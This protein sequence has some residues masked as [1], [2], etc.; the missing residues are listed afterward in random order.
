MKFK[1][2]LLVFIVLHFAKTSY[3]QNDYQI[4]AKVVDSAGYAPSG[5][6]LA[7]QPQD[8]SLIKGTFFYDGDLNIKVNV[9]KVLLKLTS[10]EFQDY[11]ILVDN[12][13]QA[14]LDLGELVVTIGT[15][16]L[17]EVVLSSSKPIYNRKQNGT[18]EVIVEN[19]LLS[20]SSNIVDVLS[21]TPEL[22]LTESGDLSV[23]G[24][25]EAAYYVNDR[26][27]TNEQLTL[28]APSNI[29]SIEIIRNPP[30]RYDAQGAAVI[31]IKTIRDMDNGYQ[32]ALGQ[33]ASYSE[34]GGAL[35]QTHFNFNLKKNK[36]Q[37]NA[38]YAL[39]LGKERERLLTS[40]DRAPENVFL[41]TDISNDDF[42]DFNNYSN[43]NLGLQYDINDDSY[44]S[45]DYSG[46]YHQL[47]GARESTNTIVDGM[48]TS[49]YDTSTEFDEEDGNNSISINYFKELDS[50]GSSLFGGGH[51]SK[52]DITTINPIE[53][54]E[55]MD[56]TEATRLIRNNQFL[57]IEILSG[58]LDFKN[59]LNASTSIESGIKYSILEN[60]FIADFRVSED[61]INFARD[62]DF[63]NTFNYQEKVAAGYVSIES[64]ISKKVDLALGVRAEHT[65][66]MLDDSR[67]DAVI[68][69][70]YLQF[71]PNASV[72]VSPKEGVNYS[73]SYISRL[74]RALYSWLNPVLVY[75][76]P[77]TG[78]QGNPQLV[79][80]LTHS[81]E[82]NAQYPNLNFLFGYKYVFDPFGQ[83]A[84]RGDSDN[85]YILTRIN[86]KSSEEFY[87]SLDK[88]YTIT[89]W[90]TSK[91]T[92][93]LSYTNLQ[94]DVFGFRRVTPRPQ[95]YY[96][97]NNSFV[98]P[99]AFKA[100]L[101]FWYVGVYKEGLHKRNS[102]FNL[103]ISLEKKFLNDK[104]TCRLIANDIFDGIIASGDYFV[105]E[106][107]VYYN[108]R[109]SYNYFRLSLGYTFGKLQN[110]KYRN[111]NIGKSEI[112]RVE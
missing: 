73:F 107:D 22:T 52:F 47:G 76:D 101:L 34:F 92:V 36:L 59:Y 33:N 45:L 25:G 46:Q 28:I 20:S 83:A 90:W 61:G 53:E 98:L 18:L 81:L 108:R 63:S 21:R 71:F 106:T 8:S 96:Y 3:S 43:Y 94:D 82:I 72:S 39:Q 75:Q 102:M 65:D 23:L 60:D 77:F 67:L 86:Y 42:R 88:S 13:G 15:N 32:L 6:V 37:W 16:V 24:R 35:Y 31:N 104:L 89:N 10:I 30:A 9:E 112:D 91:N 66:Y 99:K 2:L 48:G 93:Y 109:W 80:E 78:V 97:T 57:D 95:V 70:D 55:T 17:D 19:T 103:T 87:V 38:S 1:Q 62:D 58:Q 68:R 40:R 64:K 27:I 12:P 49:F 56:E 4:R 41:N 100:E 54:T 50:L 26:R 84:L 51:Y 11:Y 5:N 7:L 111:K 105:D 29:K 85:S 110:S 74:R 14:I 79:P 69:D 44:I